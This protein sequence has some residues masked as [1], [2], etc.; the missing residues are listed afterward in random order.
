MMELSPDFVMSK[1][2]TLC[3]S[4][5]AGQTLRNLKLWDL[6]PKEHKELLGKTNGI[7]AYGGMYRLFGF[8]CEHDCIEMN[9]WNNPQHWK[10][11]WRHDLTEYVCFG[12]T[13]WGDQYAYKYQSLLEGRSNV[14]FLEHVSMSQV[15]VF[16]CFLEFWDEFMRCSITPYNSMDILARKKYDKI[17]WDQHIT[18][19]PS[20]LIAGEEKI[21][22]TM[23]LPAR[24]SMICNG[25]L[26]R[27]LADETFDHE[28]SSVESFIDE[29]GR[30]RLR[31]HWME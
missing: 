8:E 29:Q 6:L 22:N 1:D 9:L 21:E 20:L 23:I 25:D 24:V 12:E 3:P 2:I 18:Y 28:I 11:A 16:E 27:Q 5:E 17:L 31:V 30:P 19:T 7:S 4:L 13:A 14:V 26:E 10:F 15:L